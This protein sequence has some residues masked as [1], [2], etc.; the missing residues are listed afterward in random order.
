MKI[1]HIIPTYNE[2]ENIGPM[3]DIINKIG[4]KY[5]KWINYIVVVDDKSPDG[6]AQVVRKYMKK[7]S[8]IHLISKEK[9]GLGRGIS[10][11]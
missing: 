5:P 9:E 6:T 11:P 4:S 2:K 7:N 10:L 3:M 8:R 1:A